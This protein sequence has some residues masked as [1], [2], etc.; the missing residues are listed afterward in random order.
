MTEELD[1]E[2]LIGTKLV[3]GFRSIFEKDSRFV[4]NKKQE[5]TEIIITVD[6]PDSLELPRKLPHLIV[7]QITLQNNP[8]TS[9]GYNFMRDIEYKGL[10]NGAQ[11]YAFI[12][13]YSVTLLCVG[14]QNTSRELGSRVIW[15]STFAGINYLSE[16]LGLQI[17]NISKGTTNP[18]KQFPEKTFETPIQLSGTY[19]WIGRK[20]PEDALFDLDKPLK[21][22]NIDFTK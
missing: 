4:Y 15:Y 9:F 21:N 22:I 7:S 5:E 2:H 11:E 18:S 19:Y 3:K 14:E 12:I 1:I 17:S 8:Q 20:K 10:K 6:Y 16:R 13:P